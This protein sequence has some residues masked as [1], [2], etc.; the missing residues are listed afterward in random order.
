MKSFE[1]PLT[2]RAPASHFTFYIAESDA[3]SANDKL[4]THRFN[5]LTSENPTALV[6]AR[7]CS[8]H[9]V[10]IV[11]STVVLLNGLCIINTLYKMSALIKTRGYFVRM[12]KSLGLA[13]KAS[14]KIRHATQRPP[15]G[16]HDSEFLAELVDFSVSQHKLLEHFEAGT[17]MEVR[18]AALQAHRAKW[19]RV[20]HLIGRVS[21][22]NASIEVFSDGSFTDEAIM[23]ELEE[24]IVQLLMAHQPCSPI[25]KK[26][27]KLGPSCEWFARFVLFGNLLKHVFKHAF[28]A[29]EVGP[30]Q[31]PL[32]L[33][34]DMDPMMLF[35]ATRSIRVRAG[36]AFLDQGDHRV[37]VII[38]A[39]VLEVTRHLTAFFLNAQRACVR[40]SDYPGLIVLANTAYSPVITALQYVSSF[41]AGACRR[42]V[43]VY[44]AAGASSLLEWTQQ[45]PPPSSEDTNCFYAGI[46]LD[47][48]ADWSCTRGV[49]V[50]LSLVG[51]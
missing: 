22:T 13:L 32:E 40:G 42:L 43:L 23:K 5:Q 29:F 51:R 19:E 21:V 48:R 41:L 30:K 15:V 2:S 10:S 1:E 20:M 26:W 45:F 28:G 4:I 9:Q 11:E 8:C 38:A 24:G 37:G 27:T 44:H 14:V 6:A 47:S 49:P 46:L 17:P 50:P 18:D 12:I 33:D 34:P 25:L 3:A 39:L 16:S 36:Q 31:K 35:K 7:D